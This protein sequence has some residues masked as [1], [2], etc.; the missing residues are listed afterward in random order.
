MVREQDDVSV[1]VV[2][3]YPLTFA[4]YKKCSR[5]LQ[6]GEV[7]RNP[8]RG[9]MLIGYVMGCP[10]CGFSAWVNHDDCGTQKGAGFVEDPPTNVQVGIA[11]MRKIVA[12]KVSQV[13]VRC[14]R[15]IRVFEGQLQA[16]EVAP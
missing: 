2:A 12:M 4:S 7:K 9:A 10:A 3:S 1:R 6:R 8:Q 15:T 11:V 5:F 13:C 16:V 14:R